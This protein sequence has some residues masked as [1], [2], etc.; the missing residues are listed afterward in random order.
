MILWTFYNADWFLN[1]VYQEFNIFCLPEYKVNMNPA[2]KVK[3]GRNEIS[4]CNVISALKQ[5]NFW[6]LI[7][8]SLEPVTSLLV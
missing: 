7:Y 6:P 8:F 5:V 2:G 4:I 1:G 3:L